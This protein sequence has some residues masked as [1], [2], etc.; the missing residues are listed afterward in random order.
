MQNGTVEWFDEKKG[1]GF[2]SSG[3][4]DFFVHFKAIQGEGFKTLKQGERVSFEPDESQ[5]GPVA[6]NV[7][8]QHET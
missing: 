1:F 8:V 2:I 7:K 4:N 3:G 5:K 6:K